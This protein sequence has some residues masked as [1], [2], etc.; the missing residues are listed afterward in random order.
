MGKGQIAMGTELETCLTSMG[1]RWVRCLPWSLVCPLIVAANALQCLRLVRHL[2]ARL[3]VAL[4]G[5]PQVRFDF[6][7]VVNSC[8]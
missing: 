3:T 5:E 8:V 6:L 4:N 2:G 7:C 1:L